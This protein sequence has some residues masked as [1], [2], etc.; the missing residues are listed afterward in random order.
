MRSAM[1]DLRQRAAWAGMAGPTLFVAIFMLEG[2]LRPGYNPCAMYV[3][4]LSLG[5]RG[6][7]QIANFVVFGV[8]LLVF[9]RGVAAEFP[10]G[11][12]SRG[13][14]ILLPIIAICY[15]LS[16]PFLMDPMGTPEHQMSIH[17]ML[18]GIFGAIVFLLMPISCFIYLRRFRVDPR[19]HALRWWTL[20]LGTISGAGVVLLTIATKLSD[21]QNVLHDWL[22]LIQR[23]AIVPFMI[24]LFTFALGLFRRSKTGRMR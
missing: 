19:W 4:A 9:A 17:G 6:W 11:K 21:P 12:A 10:N 3:S 14:L 16:G 15:L 2:W 1:L 18:H 5:Q 20:G 13:G 24:W 8:L 7:I 23:I 22:G